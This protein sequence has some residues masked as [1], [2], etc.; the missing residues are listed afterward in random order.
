MALEPEKFKEEQAERARS[1]R[2]ALL[3]IAKNAEANKLLKVE[4]NLESFQLFRPIRLCEETAGSFISTL[5]HYPPFATTVMTMRW[6]R[7]Q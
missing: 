2:G 6:H 4:S 5:S 3:R 1:R 7:K